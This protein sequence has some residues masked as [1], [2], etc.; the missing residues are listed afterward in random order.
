MNPA[1]ALS[2]ID[3]VDAGNL[4]QQLARRISGLIKHGTL[5]PGER[6]PSVR[7]LS[8]QQEVSIATVMQAY[9]LLENEGF[10]EARPQSGYY[11]RTERVVRLPEP[12]MVRPRPRASKVNVGDLVME[13]V[14]SASD[15]RYVNLGTALP[16]AELFPNEQLQRAMSRAARRHLATSNT[17]DTSAGHRALRVQIARRAIDAGCSLSPDDIIITNG[18]TH[19][20]QLAL[21]SVAQPGDTIAVES[22]AYYGVLHIIESLGMQACE[23]PTYPRQGICLEELEARLDCCNVKACVF[24]LNFSNPLGSCMPDDKKGRLV[25][26]LSRRSVPLIEDD[27]AGELAHDG[28]RPKTARSFDQRGEVLLCSSFSKT[29]APGYRVGWIVPGNYYDRAE[30]FR[31]VTTC[32]MPAPTQ[33][34]IAEYLA[35]DSYDL[36]LRKLRRFYVNQFARMTDAIGRHFPA[37]TKATRPGGGQVMWLEMPP[38]LDSGELYRQALERQISIAPGTMFSPTRKFRNNIRL[39]CGVA[40]NER[41]ERALATLGKLAHGLLA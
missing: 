16:A 7:K 29:L 17:C 35:N 11:V 10:I 21:Q 31:F 27:I 22:P 28:R 18:A 41:T 38:G 9:R 19:A 15:P 5:R 1:T 14:R 34:A 13:V 4:Y 6:V 32:A 39:N 37:G 3:G 12:E 26:L 8:E 30:Y 23:I 25:E 40:W 2:Q 20:L 33:M 36:H 24:C